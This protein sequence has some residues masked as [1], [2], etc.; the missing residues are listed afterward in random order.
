MV[1]AA[2]LA[3]AAAPNVKAVYAA[4]GKWINITNGGTFSSPLGVAVDR[5]GDVFVA[6]SGNNTVEELP[7]GSTTWTTISGPFDQPAD[8]AVDG[9]GDL[10]VTNE[11]NNTVEELPSGS[12]TWQA[13]SGSF[14]EPW[15]IAV[16]R[17]GDV[18]VANNGNS[19]VEELPSGSSQWNAIVGPFDKPQGIAVDGQGDLFVVN[20]GDA[21]T[22]AVIELPSSG[23]GTWTDITPPG[24]QIHPDDVAV[25]GTGNI[26]V[27]YFNA[28]TNAV[29]ER[30]A[31]SSS[32]VGL[33]DGQLVDYPEGIAV[34]GSESLFVSNFPANTM[35]EYVLPTPI[36]WTPP[37]LVP[38]SVTLGGTHAQ[39]IGNLGYN[40]PQAVAN[41]SY[42]GY[43]EERAAVEAGAS[44]GGEGTDSSYLSAILDGSGVGLQQHVSATEQGQFAALYQS[45]G[46]IPTWT[47]NTVNIGRGVHALIQAGAPTL[48]IEN[49]LVQ[50]DGYSWAEAEAQA[51]AGFPIQ[52]P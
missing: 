35:A 4:Q 13:L 51:Q 45:L 28:T 25:D 3:I 29:E 16:D 23:S 1:A 43:V 52:A 24:A 22:D 21:A 2:L 31:G 40:P 39:V 26:F 7:S 5:Q 17:Q 20:N 37:V 19:T 44:F 10:F 12:H 18:F 33:A 46:I 50:L 11:G 14:A 34:G 49:Y 42:V 48:A 41:G 27:V 15:G 32:W 30:P 38:E 47:D 9:Q 6:N 36:P 8:I